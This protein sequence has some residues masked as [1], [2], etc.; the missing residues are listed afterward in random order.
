MGADWLDAR[1]REAWALIGQGDHF[2]IG[3]RFLLAHGAL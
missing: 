2:G 1:R 3:R